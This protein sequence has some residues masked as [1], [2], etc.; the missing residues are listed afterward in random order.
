MFLNS[1]TFKKIRSLGFLDNIYL[2]ICLFLNLLFSFLLFLLLFLLLLLFLRLISNFFFFCRSKQLIFHIDWLLL[3]FIF[4]RF[5]GAW[6]W[7]FATLLLSLL[8][9]TIVLRLHSFRMLLD[10]HLLLYFLIIFL[11]FYILHNSTR[12]D[13]EFIK[14]LDTIT[15]YKIDNIIFKLILLLFITTLDVFIT[16]PDILY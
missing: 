10:I 7:F 12:L 15:L 3:F 6:R 1:L 2:I 8:L 11:I 13:S 9:K 4:W 16:T 5:R 14:D